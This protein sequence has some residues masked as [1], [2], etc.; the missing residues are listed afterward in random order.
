MGIKELAILLDFYYRIGKEK[1]DIVSM[2]LCFGIKYAKLISENQY[3]PEDIVKYSS[4]KNTHH[5]IEVRE[6]IKLAKYV[7]LKE[8]VL[9][10]DVAPIVAPAPSI[11]TSV[12]AIEPVKK[13][14]ITN[15]ANRSES[16]WVEERLR[17][18]GKMSFICILYPELKKNIDITI[19]ELSMKY[20]IFKEYELN[21]Q[22]TKLSSARAIFR[23]NKIEVAL[24]HIIES[25]NVTNEI[26]QRARTAL[27]EYTHKPV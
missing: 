11:I 18:V 24:K 13:T 26:R 20:P 12:P 6:G 10:D 9:F 17:A 21:S 5:A 22:R 16:D 25:K 1:N 19:E 3:S 23:E 4:I 2:I 14:I 27:F 8:N 7:S 15:A